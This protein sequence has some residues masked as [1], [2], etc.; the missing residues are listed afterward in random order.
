[1]SGEHCCLYRVDGATVPTNRDDG[2][3]GIRDVAKRAG[4]SLGTVSNVLNRPDYVSEKNLKKVRA[5]M[6]SL[7]FIPSGLIGAIVPDVGNP[8]WAS[9]LLGIEQVCDEHHMRMIVSSTR[10]SR[11]KEKEA[12]RMLMHQGVDGLIIAPINVRC[13]EL[14]AF[15]S[16]LG[17][18]S[19]GETPMTRYV[20][21][22]GLEGMFLA[23]R[24]LLEL[25]HRHIALI[26]GKDFVSWCMARKVGVEKAL[27]EFGCDPSVYLHEYVVDDMT[28]HEGYM[29]ANRIFSDGKAEG[30]ENIT[31]V[32]CANDV[33]ALGVMLSCKEHAVS[34]PEDLSVIGYDDVDFAPALSPSLTTVHQESYEIGK[35]AAMLLITGESAVDDRHLSEVRLVVRQSIGPVPS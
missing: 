26:N 14:T 12:L 17:I 6:D 29:M 7:G 32:I 31:A 9:V 18:V 34:I 15:R 21:S 33:L 13:E 22:N 11:E 8:Y 5:A 1:M 23:T 24:K 20:G 16:R 28:T 19:I 30:S 3:I 4:V 25:G 27:R 2:K 10:Q 35:S